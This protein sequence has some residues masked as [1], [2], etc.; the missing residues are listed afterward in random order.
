MT[1]KQDSKKTI[2]LYSPDIDFCLSLSMLL[3]DRFDI[4]TTTD[5][6]MLCDLAQSLR[7]V[8]LIADAIPT[9]KLRYKF[10]VLKGELPDLRIVMFYVSRLNT[11][12]IQQEIRKFVD[13]AYSKPVDI[14]ELTK[15]IHTMV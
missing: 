11:K 6:E 14:E 3:Q 8:V 9:F 13:A 1:E 15:C 7:P 12:G 5:D 2:L 10:E 4:V